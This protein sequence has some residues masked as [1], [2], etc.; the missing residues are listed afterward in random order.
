MEGTTLRAGIIHVMVACDTEVQH[1]WLLSLRDAGKA[2]RGHS[3]TRQDQG[4]LDVG[5]FFSFL[6]LY[7]VGRTPWTEHQPVA[8]PLPSHRETQTEQTQ[9]NIHALSGI[10][11]HEPSVR[12]GEG[13]S[14]RLLQVLCAIILRNP[15][16]TMLI[17]HSVS[18]NETVSMQNGKFN[19]RCQIH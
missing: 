13:H 9:T 7:T 18:F 1:R 17:L 16:S 10:R 11:T 12:A 5:C 8:R 15:K 19:F 14:D 4:L 3:T 2:S 6:I